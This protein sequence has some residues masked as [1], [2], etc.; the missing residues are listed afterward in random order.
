MVLHHPLATE[1]VLRY[2]SCLSGPPETDKR[3]AKPGIDLKDA[4]LRSS[5]LVNVR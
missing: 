5:I 4:T 3:L 2:R 1:Q